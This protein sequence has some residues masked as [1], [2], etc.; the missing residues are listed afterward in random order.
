MNG[1]GL[2]NGQEQQLQRIARVDPVVELDPAAGTGERGIE[3]GERPLVL[4][5]EPG[6]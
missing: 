2:A 6:R 3:S 1:A 4:E 5:L